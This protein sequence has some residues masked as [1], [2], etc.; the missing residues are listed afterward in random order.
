M[1][2]DLA[3]IILS[4]C[5]MGTPSSRNKPKANWQRTFNLFNTMMNV[6]TLYVNWFYSIHKLI[7]AA[8][9]KIKRNRI[10]CRWR[11]FSITL[12]FK[13][14]DWEENWR[15]SGKNSANKQPSHVNLQRECVNAQVTQQLPI[16]FSVTSAKRF[17]N[18]GMVYSITWNFKKQNTNFS[19]GE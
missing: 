4:I 14:N 8:K 1:I 13:S 17:S 6:T 9:L 2:T 10:V 12:R 3:S 11:K 19:S 15:K 7:T 5:V 16:A 18:V